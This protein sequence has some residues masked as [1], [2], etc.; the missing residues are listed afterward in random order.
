[1]IDSTS[2]FEFPKDE[3]ILHKIPYNFLCEMA[4]IQMVCPLCNRIL[5]LKLLTNLPLTIVNQQCFCGYKK[6]VSLL[7]FLHLNDV[8]QKIIGNWIE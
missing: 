4:K 7:A 2:F 6:S 3:P 5:L 1:M 8:S